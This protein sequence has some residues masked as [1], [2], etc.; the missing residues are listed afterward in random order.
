M[1]AGACW[2]WGEGLDFGGASPHH[3]PNQSWGSPGWNEDWPLNLT[4]FPP[5]RAGAG[6]PHPLPPHPWPPTLFLS[7]QW[8]DRRV[9]RLPPQFQSPLGG[10]GGVHTGRD[11]WVGAGRAAA[12]A[13]AAVLIDCS[14]CH[15]SHHAAGLQLM[16]TLP[17]QHLSVWLV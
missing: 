9:Q 8:G 16:L 2:R 15:C 4:S 12:C 6:P 3:P 17:L 5:S 7:G 13:G 14:Y 11:G 1:G 10:C